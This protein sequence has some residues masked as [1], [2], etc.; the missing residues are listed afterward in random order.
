MLSSFKHQNVASRHR[1]FKLREI[2]FREYSYKE[3]GTYDRVVYFMRSMVID[4]KLVDFSMKMCENY[5][6][7]WGTTER[8]Q[9]AGA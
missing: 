2:D 6:V 3:G 9:G 1:T 8:V 4:L 5:M 7:E